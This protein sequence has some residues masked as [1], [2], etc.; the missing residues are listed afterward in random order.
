MGTAKNKYKA[1]GGGLS[2]ILLFV[3]IFVGIVG[4][5][6]LII[7]AFSVGAI[8]VCIAFIYALWFNSRF[9]G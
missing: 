7:G 5:I 4:V 3:A 6:S 9:N 2:I 8:L 1:K